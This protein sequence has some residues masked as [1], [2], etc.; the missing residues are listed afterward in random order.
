MITKLGY[1]QQLINIL[2]PSPTDDRKLR[3]QEAA[4]A[5]SQARDRLLK[6]EILQNKLETNSIYGNWLST[7]FDNKTYFDKNLGK[8]AIKLPA[9]PIS[10]IGDMGVYHV[11]PQGEEENMFI[12]VTTG[13]SAMHLKTLSKM[14]GGNMGYYLDGN[15]IV[16]LNKISTDQPITIR[17]VAMGEDIPLDDYFPIDGSIEQEML[18]LAVN[19]YSTQKQINEDIISDSISQ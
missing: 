14:L 7:F 19:L 1:A 6:R 16:F 18:E 9:R 8:Y 12:P 3:E 5:I 13:F 17:M 4:L 10:L 15:K 2:Y 11:F